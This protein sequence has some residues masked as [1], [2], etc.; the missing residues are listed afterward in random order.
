MQKSRLITTYNHDFWDK[1]VTGLAYLP[2]YHGMKQQEKEKILT[3]LRNILCIL[4]NEA[5]EILV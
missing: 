1:P 4:C 5:I 2:G 3:W